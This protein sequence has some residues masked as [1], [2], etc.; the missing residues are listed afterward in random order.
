LVCGPGQ[1]WQSPVEREKLD[2]TPVFWH[3]NGEGKRRS[4]S[5]GGRF[6]GV[7]ADIDTVKAVVRSEGDHRQ[8]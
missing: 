1:G 7:V 4:L 5:F 3:G 8:S 2:K 6:A